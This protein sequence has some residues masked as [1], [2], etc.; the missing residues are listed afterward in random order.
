MKPTSPLRAYHVNAGAA[1]A[2]VARF[3]DH[4]VEGAHDSAA[5][6][7]VV[8]FDARDGTEIVLELG[9]TDQG[10]VLI[11]FTAGPNPPQLK[12]RVSITASDPI[13]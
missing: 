3:D 6:D 5:A 4:Q 10:R 2:V 9:T 7:V 11:V 8:E 1:V 12:P 13:D